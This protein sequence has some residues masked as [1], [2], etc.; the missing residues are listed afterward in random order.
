MKFTKEHA[1]SGMVIIS[2][3]V[4]AYSL[5][6]HAGIIFYEDGKYYVYDNDPDNPINEF[7]G[8]VKKSS[9]E[10]YIKVNEVIEF[11]ETGMTSDAI[12]EKAKPYFSKRFSWT[13]FNCE[14]FIEKVT[15]EKI[16][17]KS[18]HPIQ[19]IGV[20]FG[21]SSLLLIFGLRIK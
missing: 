10:D 21:V 20:G 6:R 13:S 17:R 3:F 1:K 8:S 5:Y 19:Q 14:D 7:G 11:Y 9:L 2:R 18:M 4:P 12:K 15:G 16:K